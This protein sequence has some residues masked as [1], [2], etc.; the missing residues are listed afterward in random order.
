MQEAGCA[1][2]NFASPRFNILVTHYKWQIITLI[3]LT[4]ISDE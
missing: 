2:G 4:T 1:A 3:D